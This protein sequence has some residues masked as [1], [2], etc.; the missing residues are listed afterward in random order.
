MAD[1]ASVEMKKMYEQARVRLKEILEK[2][3]N[4]P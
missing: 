2:Q 4:K 1:E 3:R